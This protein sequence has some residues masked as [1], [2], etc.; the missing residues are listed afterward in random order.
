MG[1]KK[2]L[3]LE[4]G[5]LLLFVLVVDSGYDAVFQVALRVHVP[6]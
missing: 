6:K 2:D 3:G 5:G 1:L 4:D